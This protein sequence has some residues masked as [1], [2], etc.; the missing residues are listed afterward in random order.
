MRIDAYNAISQL[1]QTKSV[2]SVKKASG[3][4]SFSDRLEFSSTAKSYQT[5]RTAVAEAPD[6]RMDKIAQIKAQMSAGTYNI[7]SEAVADK[8]LENA[9]TLTF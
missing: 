6:V 4:Q 2:S 9:E 8:I 3:T 7:S 5:A 1:Y